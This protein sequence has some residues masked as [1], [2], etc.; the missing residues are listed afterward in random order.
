MYLLLHW[1]VV[2]AMR[3]PSNVFYASL[4]RGR[5]NDQCAKRENTDNEQ[6]LN[7]KQIFVSFT[8]WWSH[9]IF[10]FSNRDHLCPR[11]LVQGNLGSFNAQLD[12]RAERGDVEG[13]VSVAV[14]LVMFCLFRCSYPQKNYSQ[15]CF[16]LMGTVHFSHF[17]QL[18]KTQK[19]TSLYKLLLLWKLRA[20]TGL[21]CISH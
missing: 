2:L 18:K 15:I 7:L 5:W 12:V 11:A 6:Q 17:V 20:S 1:T 13:A 8:M 9:H 19:A 3:I 21:S 16:F 4:L 14:C 10:T